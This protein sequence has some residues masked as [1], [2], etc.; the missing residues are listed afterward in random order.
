MYSAEYGISFHRNP[1]SASE[2]GDV[3]AFD[4][5]SKAYYGNILGGC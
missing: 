1:K 3:Q 4:V 5:M 2:L